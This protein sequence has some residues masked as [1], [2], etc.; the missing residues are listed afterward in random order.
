MEQDLASHAVAVATAT[1]DLKRHVL[2]PTPET[3]AD[4]R[5]QVRVMVE[6]ACYE[7]WG[8]LKHQSP[9]H[10]IRRLRAY[11][12]IL[13]W[14]LSLAVLGPLMLWL[15]TRTDLVEKPAKELFAVVALIG[16]ALVVLAEIGILIARDL[17]EL[18]KARR[19]VAGK[20]PG[21][22]SK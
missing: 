10:A 18:R 8:L 20:L 14:T 16:P 19:A 4:L 9:E 11:R 17:P 13:I 5:K 1:R 12:G 22:K 21:R 15:G 3:L 7:R 6:A 2:V